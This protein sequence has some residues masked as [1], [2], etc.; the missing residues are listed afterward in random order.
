MADAPQ[1]AGWTPPARVTGVTDIPYTNIAPPGYSMPYASWAAQM[2]D[3]RRVASGSGMYVND[4]YAN[5]ANGRTGLMGQP[6][7][8]GGGVYQPPGGA[9]TPPGSTPSGATPPGSTPPSSTPS[10]PQNGPTGQ[11]TFIPPAPTAGMPDW[12]A[13]INKLYGPGDPLAE[14]K[15][16]MGTTTNTFG[17]SIGADGKRTGGVQY[18]R[19]NMSSLADMRRQWQAAGMDPDTAIALQTAIG[20]PNGDVGRQYAQA[21]GLGQQFDA[22]GGLLGLRVR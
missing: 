4:R 17:G 6:T 10:N 18:T 13:A 9:Y 8:G 7:V 5:I 12:S 16:A 3:A 19:T 11:G 22:P 2:A 15:N 1:T 14:I 21:L 20:M